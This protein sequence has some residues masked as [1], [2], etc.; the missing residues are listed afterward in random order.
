M[1]TRYLVD[2]A[3]AF[4]RFYHD[5]PILVEDSDLRT[6]RLALVEGVRITLRNGLKLI[7]L[8]APEEM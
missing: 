7:G 4:N 1:V 5:C 3:Q 6:A 2:T 8:Q